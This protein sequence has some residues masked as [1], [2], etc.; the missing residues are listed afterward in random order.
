MEYNNTSQNLKSTMHF[1]YI[2]ICDPKKCY[3][4]LVFN[5]ENMAFYCENILN[6]YIQI[7]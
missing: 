4:G 2:N 6:I 7:N 5:T 1:T 3:K